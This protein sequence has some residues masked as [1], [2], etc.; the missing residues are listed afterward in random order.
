MGRMSHGQNCCRTRLLV[1]ML[2]LNGQSHPNSW[3][4]WSRIAAA[5]Q[6]K[7]VQEPQML[8]AT[9]LKLPLSYPMMVLNSAG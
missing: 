7:R 4:A 6:S 5:K 1:P 2:G 3:V 9:C 8:V